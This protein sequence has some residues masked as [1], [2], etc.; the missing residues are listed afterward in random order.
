MVL[1]SHS[2]SNFSLSQLT[3]LLLYSLTPP[4]ILFYLSLHIHCWY[5]YRTGLDQLEDSDCSAL[6]DSVVA[7]ILGRSR[8]RGLL[9]DAA[10]LLK[11][12]AAVGDMH[13]HSL[14]RFRFFHLSLSHT[15]AFDLTR[16]TGVDWEMLERRGGNKIVA[17]LSA[18]VITEVIF[19]YR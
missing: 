10:S 3:L 16:H 17:C 7:D 13:F 1:L 18:I 2:L 19:T 4:L 6:I 9:L 11:S 8:N 15:D 12:L 14:H 5:P